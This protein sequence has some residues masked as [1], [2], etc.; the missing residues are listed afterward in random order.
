MTNFEKTRILSTM[1]G[2]FIAGLSTEVTTRLESRAGLFEVVGL[3]T[4]TILISNFI[5]MFSSQVNAKFTMKT[6]LKCRYIA[7]LSMSVAEIIALVTYCLYGSGRYLLLPVVGIVI[8]TAI[9]FLFGGVV[10]DKLA[11]MNIPEYSRIASKSKSLG[12]VA[13]SLGLGIVGLVSVLKCEYIIP[14]LVIV[15][16]VVELVIIVKYHKAILNKEW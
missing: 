3:L 9:T 5:A 14:Y 6:V 15:G 11:G 16:I 2:C 10:V 13:S 1:V 8:L 12:A 7:F 4:A